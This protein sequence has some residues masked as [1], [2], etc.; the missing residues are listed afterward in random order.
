MAVQWPLIIFTL[1]TCMSAGI[2]GMQGFLAYRDKGGDLQLPAL[3]VS[4]VFIGIGGIA[5]FLHLQHWDRIFNG[6]GHLTSGIT[7]ELIGI[8]LIAIMMVVYFLVL[9]KKGTVPKWAAGMAMVAS[10]LLVF[11]MGHSYLMESRLIWNTYLLPAYYLASAFMLGSLAVWLIASVLKVDDAMPICAKASLI[12]C[13]VMLV[14]VFAYVAFISTV[15]FSAVGYYF[16]PTSPTTG[17]ADP[18]TYSTTLLT[19][20][21]APTFWLGVVAIG[22]VLPFIISWMGRK[23]TEVGAKLSRL[24]AAALVLTLAGGLCWRVALYVLGASV[25]VFY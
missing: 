4:V 5:S 16:D 1:C 21:L 8:A 11:I 18:T 10:A 20:Q 13:G 15:T 2:F 23:A 7:Q 19:G 22:I 17:M 12:S 25:F 24:L 9:R 3:I 6:F 14:V